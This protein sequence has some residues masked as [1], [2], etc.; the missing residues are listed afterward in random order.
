MTI[1]IPLRIRQTF[2]AVERAPFPGLALISPGG[3][4]LN[5]LLEGRMAT[6]SLNLK[7]LMF[8]VADSNPYFSRIVVGL[9]RSFGANN[10]AEVRNSYDAIRMLNGQK[11]DIL[12]CDDK[13]PPHG[14][15]Q[16]THAIRRKADNE[17]R[18]VPIMIMAG[19][20]RE[21]MIKIA[22]DAGA[23]MVIAKPLS[24]TSLYD[25]LSWIAFNPR[26]F[27]DTETYYGPDRRFKIEGYPGGVGRRKADKDQQ[28]AA[29]SGPA[30]V[31]SEIDNLFKSARIGS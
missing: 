18:N 8:L 15:L 13:L 1:F 2:G 27:V 30:M 7:G 22:R 24:P 17:N 4:P 20:T 19:D 23:N 3:A 26:Q 21:S 6:Q 29:E 14:G 11:V 5:D 28:I 31:Q 25:R 16:V 10:I 9:L 12:L